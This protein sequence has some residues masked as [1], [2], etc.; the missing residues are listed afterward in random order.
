[1]SENFPGSNCFGIGFEAASSASPC[2]P[3]SGET[4]CR[5]TQDDPLECDL[6]REWT[7]SEKRVVAYCA[8]RVVYIPKRVDEFGVAVDDLAKQFS[9]CKNMVNL[10]EWQPYTRGASGRESE[11]YTNNWRSTARFLCFWNWDYVWRNN[12]CLDK[13]RFLDEECWHGVACNGASSAYDAYQLSCLDQVQG[14]RCT[15]SILQRAGRP[16]CECGFLQP[17]VGFACGAA[18]DAC[19]GHSCVWN[20]GDGNRYCDYYSYHLGSWGT[21]GQSGR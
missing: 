3:T 16:Q 20:T 17:W 12:K 2:L 18:D 6:V 11:K 19:N 21:L 10:N 7:D 15:P 1:M 8:D 5:C 4:V 13:H 9:V 14:S